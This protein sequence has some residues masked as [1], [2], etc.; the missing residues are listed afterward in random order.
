MRKREI[1]IKILVRIDNTKYEVHDKNRYHEDWDLEQVA[2]AELDLF[3]EKIKNSLQPC[4]Y[5]HETLN[6]YLENKAK[7]DES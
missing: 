2:A 3:A 4:F 6:K 1:E 5:D 7:N